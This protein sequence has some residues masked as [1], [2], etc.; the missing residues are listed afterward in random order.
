MAV[1]CATHGVRVNSINPGVVYSDFHTRQGMSSDARDQFEKSVADSTLL[2]R[3]GQPL[4]IAK[5]VVVMASNDAA[6]VTGANWLVDGG[7]ALFIPYAVP[8]LYESTAT[9]S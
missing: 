1:R 6:Y 7:R 2:G 8:T 5:I 3:S 4:E 9:D